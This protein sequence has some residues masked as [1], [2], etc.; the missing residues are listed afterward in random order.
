VVN[1]GNPLNSKSNLH[2]DPFI[3]A[4]QITIGP[5]CLT[6]AGGHKNVQQK[7]KKSFVRTLLEQLHKNADFG[8]G[9]SWISCLFCGICS[10]SSGR[11]RTYNPSVNRS[12]GSNILALLLAATIEIPTAT[13]AGISGNTLHNNLLPI[14]TEYVGIFTESTHKSPHIS[15]VPP[16]PHGTPLL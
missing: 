5:I 10:G 1:P 11:A 4:G 3:G 16:P 9:V 13:E 7:S 2:L 14:D 8:V 12:A 6:T 15:G